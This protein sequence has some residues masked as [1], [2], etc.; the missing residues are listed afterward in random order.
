MFV[1]ERKPTL[2]PRLEAIALATLSDLKTNQDEMYNEEKFLLMMKSLTAQIVSLEDQYGSSQPSP[3][4]KSFSETSENDRFRHVA[5]MRE[6]RQSFVESLTNN[7]IPTPPA[8]NTTRA[9]TT[10]TSRANV[11]MF[12]QHTDLFESRLKAAQSNTS[13]DYPLPEVCAYYPSLWTLYLN[14]YFVCL[15]RSYGLGP[16][17]KYGHYSW[18]MFLT[19]ICLSSH[20]LFLSIHCEH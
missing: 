7:N 14:S 4:D 1:P 10:S 8:A 17:E 19:V 20:L 18:G 6:R 9:N 12:N 5:A 3:T 13:P 16:W 2:S 11:D 15:G